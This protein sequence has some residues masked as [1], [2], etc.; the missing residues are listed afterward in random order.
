MTTSNSLF[1]RSIRLR[2][3]QFSKMMYYLTRNPLST[4]GLAIT[5]LYVL[6]AVF[7]PV[8]V[9]GNPEFMRE[10]LLYHGKYIY[11]TPLP[12]QPAF[13][14]GTTYGGYDIFNGVVKGARIDLGV[15]ALVVFSGAIIGSIL[16]AIAGYKGGTISDVI[17]RVTDIFLSIP[18]IVLAVVLLL[19]LGRTLTS[20]VEALVIVWW[21]FYTRLVRGQVLTIRE[22][23][24]VEASVASGGSSIRTVVKHILPNSIYPIYV[25]IS[26]DFG[27]VILTLASLDFLGFGFAGNNLAEWGNIIG[28][29]TSGGGGVETLTNYWWT[30]LIPGL[31]LLV[32]VVALNILGD[33]IR[34]V[35]DPKSRL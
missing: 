15:S 22:Q 13:P 9:G 7:G 32:L 3:A 24:Y 17:M 34:D 10:V 12:P 33:G 28:L 2:Y 29:A 18:F 23:K 16:G 5:L 6:V 30:I 8:I 26:L 31:V 27:N 14:F 11:N 20:M 25:Q 4:A 21:P 1:F 35:T 19:V